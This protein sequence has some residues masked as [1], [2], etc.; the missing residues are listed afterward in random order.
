MWLDDILRVYFFLN[1]F[2]FI[3]L[4][5]ELFELNNFGGIL[6]RV[7]LV[8]RLFDR[9]I[10]ENF[11]LRLKICFFGVFLILF[12]CKWVFFLLIFL[13]IID[14]LLEVISIFLFVLLVLILVL[15]IF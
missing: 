7:W 11:V 9:F 15:I 12:V 4:F 3:I 8:I 2:K 5:N 10:L 6:G 14:L 13:I 1:F